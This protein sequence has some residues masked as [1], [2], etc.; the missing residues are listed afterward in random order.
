MNNGTFNVS[1]YSKLVIG[2]GSEDAGLSGN[3]ISVADEGALYDSTVKGG[4]IHG[5]NAMS[6]AGNNLMTDVTITV[7][8]T[9]GNTGS[10][11]LAGNSSV[12][13]KQ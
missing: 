2:A 10:L 11:T 1:G 7:D 5:V 12:V 3:A 4:E 9:L 13:F 6:F 8:G